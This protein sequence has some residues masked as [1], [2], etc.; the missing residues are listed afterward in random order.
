VW[1]GNLGED[2]NLTQLLADL[3]AVQAS[4]DREA[5][6]AAIRKHVPEMVVPLKL[7]SAGSL[8]TETPMDTPLSG[9]GLGLAA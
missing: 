4:Y 9:D 3:S 8:A 7:R 1:A 6:I 2:F 5:V